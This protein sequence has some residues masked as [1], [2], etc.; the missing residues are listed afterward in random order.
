[1][2]PL[3]EDSEESDLL[4][5]NI[6]CCVPL[7]VDEQE[8]EVEEEVEGKEEEEEEEV[9][10]RR[11]LLS[12]V[13]PELMERSRGNSW[14]RIF[15]ALALKSIFIFFR[16]EVGMFFQKNLGRQNLTVVLNLPEL[17]LIGPIPLNWSCE[18][19]NTGKGDFF[20]SDIW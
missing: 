8:D 11:Y 12:F 14:S 10:G 18:R 17:I 9:E 2:V 4:E 16:Q 15:I 6:V 20:I 13:E 7:V 5:D 3:V 1:M 19:E